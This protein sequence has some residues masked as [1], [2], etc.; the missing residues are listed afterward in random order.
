MSRTVILSIAA[1]TVAA[2]GYVPLHLYQGRELTW[3]SAQD[4]AQGGTGLSRTGAAVFARPEM[5]GYVDAPEVEAGVGFWWLAEQRTRMAYDRFENAIGEV[6]FADNVSFSPLPGPL[7]GAYPV[8]Y[9]LV[10][11]AGVAPVYDFGY[12]YEKL[13]L[14]D[15]YN[16]VSRDRTTQS[17]SVYSASLGAGYRALGWLSAGVSGG[18]LFGNRRLE[19]SN[20]HNDTLD[21]LLHETGSPTGVRFGGGLAAEP[22]SG[23]VV[24]AGFW[25]KVK[26]AG[27][28]QEPELD[29]AEAK[30]PW[31]ARLGFEYRAGGRL[32]SRVVAEAGYEPWSTIGRQMYDVVSVRAGVEHRLN[33]SVRLRYGFGLEPLPFDQN[34]QMV[35]VSAGVGFDAGPVVIDIGALFS[36]GVLSPL[37]FSTP[38]TPADQR[39]YETDGVFA[40]TVSREF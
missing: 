32:P 6:V 33:N 26:L 40:V 14:D 39:V 15:F 13:N 31:Q 8:G 3:F 7:A 16:V 21:V 23:F 30:R 12:R 27:F 29:Q 1:V 35:R 11:G 2:F 5:L 19:V 20:L 38:L 4:L 25:S 36:R 28:T 10:V 37:M 9:G 24:D 17:G 22:L 18:Y 34:M